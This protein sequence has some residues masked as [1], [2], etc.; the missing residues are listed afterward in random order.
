[1]REPGL[2]FLQRTDAQ[3]GLEGRTRW[4][5][6][7]NP[8]KT[9]EAHALSEVE[10]VIREAEAW[11][12]QGFHALGWIAYEAAP[13]FDPRLT[14]HPQ[15]KTGAPIAASAGATGAFECGVTNAECGVVC[16]T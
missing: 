15:R 14:V 7:R 9:L 8:E 1:M 6:F 13:A 10:G 2:I 4:V 5:H 16:P 3:N 12:A 11:Q